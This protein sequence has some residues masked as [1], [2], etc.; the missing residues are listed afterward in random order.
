MA[1]KNK[2]KTFVEKWMFLENVMLSE[3]YLDA[4]T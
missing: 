3:I 4:Q 2:F 1:I